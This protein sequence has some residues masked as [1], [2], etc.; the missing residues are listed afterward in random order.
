VGVAQIVIRD[1]DGAALLMGDKVAKQF[2]GGLAIARQN[3]CLDLRGQLRVPRQR[4]RGDRRRPGLIQ[5]GR[6][7][8][9]CSH[10]DTAA[11]D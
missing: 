10:L 6:L 3:Q 5:R 2:A 8:R 7:S 11:V 1:A 4:G 9:K